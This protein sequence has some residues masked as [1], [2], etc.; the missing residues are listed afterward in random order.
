MDGSDGD[1]NVFGNQDISEIFRSQNCVIINI[2]RCNDLKESTSDISKMWDKY[3][4]VVP[5][6]TVGL[7]KRSNSKR[8]KSLREPKL[9]F[10]SLEVRNYHIFLFEALT[11]RLYSYGNWPKSAKIWPQ[12]LAE[13]GFFYLGNNLNLK[14]SSCGLQ[15]N[16]NDWKPTDKALDLHA[17][18]NPKC[19]YLKSI[20]YSFDNKP[21]MDDR[22]VVVPD[23]IQLR[24]PEYSVIDLRINSFTTWNFHN[25]QS[26]MTLA[27]SGYF[28]TGNLKTPPPPTETIK[29]EESHKKR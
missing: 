5:P 7:S 8:K 15:T 21:K 12:E 11:Q 18:L 29:L 2:V 27:H 16:I 17:H 19:E 28:Y 14:C 20:G 24:Y 13:A 6:R 25:K 3:K 1:F 9:F 4:Q 23:G 10:S 22:N 26:P